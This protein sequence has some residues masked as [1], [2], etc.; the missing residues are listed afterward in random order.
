MLASLCEGHCL[1][2]ICGYTGG[3]ELVVTHGAL[4]LD[5]FR[6]EQVALTGAPA[7]DLAGCR[8]LEAFSYGFLCF[9]HFSDV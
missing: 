9:L 7:K 4:L 1:L 5:R 3:Y 2:H 8:N 6:T